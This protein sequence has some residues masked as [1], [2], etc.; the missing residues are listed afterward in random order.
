MVR[1][2]FQCVRV[3]HCYFWANIYD[4]DVKA[5]YFVVNVS[6]FKVYVTD[7]NINANAS[8]VNGNDFRVS[9]TYLDVN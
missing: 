6:D 2:G 9:V 3:M 5:Y 1:L 8:V 4:L 7:L